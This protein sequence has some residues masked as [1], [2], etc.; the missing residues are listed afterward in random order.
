MLKLGDI[1]YT[2]F[3]LVL[4]AC[5]SPQYKE[6]KRGETYRVK[7]SDLSSG[8]FCELQLKIP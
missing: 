5:N 1:R 6:R 2:E 3:G 4:Y 7:A 8:S